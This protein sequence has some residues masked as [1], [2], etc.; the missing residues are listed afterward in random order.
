MLY[1]PA[2]DNLLWTASQAAIT[3]DHEVALTPLSPNTTYYYSI[4][5]STDVLAG[6]SSYFFVTP[7]LAGTPVPTRVWVLGDAGTATT[8]ETSVR[9]AY[10]TYTGSTHTNLWLMLDRKSTRLNSSH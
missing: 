7:P 4:G 10:Y 1:G 3:T 2:P 8:S 9:D 5:T 6:D